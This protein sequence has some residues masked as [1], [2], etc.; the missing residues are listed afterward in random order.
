MNKLITAV[1]IAFLSFNAVAIDQCG[2]EEKRIIAMHEKSLNQGTQ[3]RSTLMAYTRITI[4]STG[5]IY[6]LVNSAT[7]IGLLSFVIFLGGSL[8]I[9][10]NGKN[11]EE[12]D[13]LEERLCT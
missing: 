3:R 6:G 12:L 9:Y 13:K 1:L 7:G 5:M 11:D 4:G 10:I 2:E 8:D